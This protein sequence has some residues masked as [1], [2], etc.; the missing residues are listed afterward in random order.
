MDALYYETHKSILDI[1]QYFQK[2]ELINCEPNVENEIQARI[3]QAT[4]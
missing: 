2:Y 3:D 1:Q 4:K